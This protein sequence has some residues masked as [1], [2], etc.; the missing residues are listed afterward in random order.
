[1]LSGEGSDNLY[2]FISRDCNIPPKEGHA[3]HEGI[4]LIDHRVNHPRLMWERLPSDDTKAIDKPHNKR[5]ASQKP[6]GKTTSHNLWTTLAATLHRDGTQLAAIFGEDIL[7]GK[8]KPP[9]INLRIVVWKFR[10]VTDD[11]DFEI[12]HWRK[13]LAKLIMAA[14][15]VENLTIAAHIECEEIRIMDSESGSSMLAAAEKR[16]SHAEAIEEEAHAT[17]REWE[18]ERMYIPSS[19]PLENGREWASAEEPLA[20][21]FVSTATELFHR[22]SYLLAFKGRDCLV[23]LKG[24]YNF[25]KGRFDPELSSKQEIFLGF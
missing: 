9:T 18:K 23:T 2:G 8:D 10:G 24:V 11:Q 19:T 20:H 4:F 14:R 15:D 1:M 25:S 5:L 6:C 7:G 21:A 17:I 3:S 13:K 16:C 22:S 12:S